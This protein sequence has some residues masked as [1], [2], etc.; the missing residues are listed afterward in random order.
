ML[1]H[2]NLA[3]GGGHACAGQPGNEKGYVVKMTDQLLDPPY[4]VSPGTRVRIESAYVGDERRLGVMGLMN[5]WVTGLE[6]PCYR[7]YGYFHYHH[8]H[9]KARRRVVDY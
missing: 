3:D 5:A 4:K 6:Y 1:H 9:P 7:E 2:H 8:W